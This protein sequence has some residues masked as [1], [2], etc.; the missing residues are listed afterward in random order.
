MMKGKCHRDSGRL[1]AYLDGELTGRQARDLAEHLKECPACS[2]ALAELQS[3]TKLLEAWQNTPAPSDNF[4]QTFWQKIAVLRHHERTHKARGM[5]AWLSELLSTRSVS[6]AASAVCAICILVASLFMVKSKTGVPED[7]VALARDFELYAN[8][9][10][11]E[12][13][14]ALE[15]FDVIAVLDVLEKDTKG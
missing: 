6:L 10:V 8:L 14:E 5:R 2:G 9:E 12:N 7:S 15:Y 13:S 3:T 4:D 11:I 1:V